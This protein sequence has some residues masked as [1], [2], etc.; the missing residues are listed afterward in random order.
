MMR[1]IALLALALS[2]MTASAHKPS[3]AYLTLERDG[4][5]V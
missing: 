3:D 4:T 1:V 5:T 2:A